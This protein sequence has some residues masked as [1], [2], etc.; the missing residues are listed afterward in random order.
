MYIVL[1]ISIN[2]LLKKIY[3]SSA[4]L[5]GSWKKRT[6]HDPCKITRPSHLV[7]LF[8]NSSNTSNLC[9]IPQ[10][11]SAVHSQ[12]PSG[13]MTEMAENVEGLSANKASSI[14]SE[15]CKIQH[16]HCLFLQETHRV[17]DQSRAKIPG[18][19]KNQASHRNNRFQTDGH[20][21]TTRNCRNH[22]TVQYGRRDTTHTSS[23]YF[24]TF[25]ICV[26]SLVWI[27]SPVH[28]TALSV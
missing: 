5:W 1:L 14:L 19:T 2:L 24:Q 9:I 6:R 17:K 8:T 23:L 3:R 4:S 20:S 25:R 7:K 10:T 15:L 16:C 18:G 21:S 26:R 28:S 11:M 12:S 22:S 27:Q 13:A